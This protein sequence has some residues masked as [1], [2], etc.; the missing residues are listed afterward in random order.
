[1]RDFFKPTNNGADMKMLTKSEMEKMSVA[2]IDAML[3]KLR[4]MLKKMRKENMVL[5]SEN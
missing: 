5:A 1:L 2:E 4:R 3:V